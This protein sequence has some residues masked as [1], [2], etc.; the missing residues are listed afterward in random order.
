M[1]LI[2]S[3]IVR[4]GGRLSSGYTV[5][6]ITQDSVTLEKNGRELALRLGEN[7]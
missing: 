3:E 4:A 7:R 6:E 2:D 5:R 1:A